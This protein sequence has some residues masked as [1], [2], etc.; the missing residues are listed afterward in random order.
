MRVVFF[1]TP[2]FAVPSLSALI[3]AGIDVAAVVSQPDRPHARSHS[4]LVP[5]PVKIRALAANIPVWQP[6]RPR[7]EL[8]HRQLRD[9]DAA[10]GIVVAYGHLLQPDLLTIPKLGM[11][12]VHASL[13]PRWRG[14]A[15]I[16]RALLAGDAETGVSIM[17]IEQ[18]LDTG[19]VWHERRTPI[20]DDDTAGTLTDRL[21]HLGAEALLEALPKIA[22]GA[23]PVPQ[24]SDGVTVARK[25]HRD[26]A[27]IA[28]NEPARTV[29]CRI[30]AMDPTPGA[31]TRI[32]GIDMKIFGANVDDT[33]DAAAP[34][35]VVPSDKALI[36]AAVNGAV[37]VREV[38]PAGKRRLPAIHWLRG[39]HLPPDARFE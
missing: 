11:I 32:N 16:Q 24:P 10:L 8:F 1:G 6:D 39:A 14:A 17:R 21:S 13:L 35:S 28:W 38:Q 19:A 36:V 2:A 3:E 23:A 31:W 34:G 37:R 33:S 12:N 5:T 7:G 4:T 22:E 9:V 15:P 30:R 26:D 27:H 29:S 25:I 18:G 20:S